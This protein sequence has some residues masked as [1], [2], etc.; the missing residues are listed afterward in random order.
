MASPRRP[1]Q[2]QLNFHLPIEYADSFSRLQDK[3]Q[4]GDKQLLMFLIDYYEIHN[5]VYL[6]R[7]RRKLLH[8]ITQGINHQ[9]LVELKLLYVALGHF[10]KTIGTL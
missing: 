10:L 2:H 6:R 8:R 3:L 7:L 1:R 9:F 5:S 4:L